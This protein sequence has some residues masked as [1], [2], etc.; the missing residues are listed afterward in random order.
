MDASWLVQ[1]LARQT[2]F[3]ESAEDCA[4]SGLEAGCAVEGAFL[5]TL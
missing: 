5:E 1:H 4:A 3:E 2:C